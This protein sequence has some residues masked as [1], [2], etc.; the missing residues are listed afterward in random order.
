[1][2]VRMMKSS[3][4]SFFLNMKRPRMG[5]RLAAVAVG[6]FFLG[7]CVAVLDQ[8]QF[9]TDPCSV[10]NLGM[11]RTLGMAFGDYQLLVNILMLL[12]VIRFDLSR[13]GAGTLVNMVG[14]GYVAQFF[15]WIFGGMPAMQNPSL[16]ARIALFVPTMIVMLVAVSIYMAA[17][18]GVA[19]YDALP[20]IIAK[21]Q[22]KVSF[23][24]VRM[25]W[26]VAALSIGWLLGSTVGVATV[27][28]GF[29]LGPVITWVSRK[30]EPFFN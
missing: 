4:A 19:P 28:T 25:A 9:G 14:V 11:A 13:I 1:M 5:R 7:L 8:I 29:C 12:I 15:M 30:V 20:Q 23:R 27:I 6:N 18:M 17:D 16:A 24:V 22:K 10:L 3:L 2:G 26:D 21:R